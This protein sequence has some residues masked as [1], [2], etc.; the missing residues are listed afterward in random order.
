MKTGLHHAGYL[1]AL[2]PLTGE[3]Q[4]TPTPAPTA[5]TQPTHT[6]I[7]AAEVA[8][9]IA[10]SE[11]AGKVGDDARELVGWG[12][13]QAHLIWR[14]EPALFFENEDYAEFYVILDGH[15]TLTVGGTLTN[16][17]RT[18]PHLEATGATGGTR[19]RVSKGDLLMVPAGTPHQ[20]TAVEGKLM[21]L[22]M[23]LPLQPKVAAAVGPAQ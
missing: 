8:Q 10:K 17:K 22:S 12:P 20:V 7:S 16:P 3:A 9:R 13:F 5:A 23:H 6:Y 15:G 2:L 18:G 11:A 4:S 21:Y 1:L 19:H 14:G